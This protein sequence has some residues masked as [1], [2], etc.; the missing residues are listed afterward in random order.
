[1]ED[2]VSY[3]LA[4]KL[5]EKGYDEG[6]YSYYENKVLRW[7]TS[8]W[9]ETQYNNDLPHITA[10]PTISQVL[11]WLRDQEISVEPLSAPYNSGWKCYVK[12]KGEIVT[13]IS[14]DKYKTYKQ[15]AIAGIEEVLDNLIENIMGKKDMSLADYQRLAMTTCMSSCENYSYMFLNLVGEVGEL[16][17]KVSK[18]IRTGHANINENKL[19]F[20]SINLKQ[21]MMLEAGDV[22]WQLSGLCSAMGWPL[23]EIAQMNLD[24]LKSRQERGVIAGNGDHR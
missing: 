16:A 10:A 8:P 14:G 19:D 5:K 24:K 15:A 9:F 21:E 20:E 22:L 1:M 11:K 17:S 23:E 3:E 7:S 4:V 18:A 13:M 12:N 2:V 6:C